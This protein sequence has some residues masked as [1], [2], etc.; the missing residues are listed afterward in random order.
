MP[1]YSSRLFRSPIDSSSIATAGQSAKTP[2]HRRA[3]PLAARGST[4]FEK[5][6]EWSL[7]TECIRG[8]SVRLSLERSGTM[9]TTRRRG[10]SWNTTSRDGVFKSETTD[11]RERE[12][13]RDL[14]RWSF[15]HTREIGLFEW[16][17]EV[18]LLFSGEPRCFRQSQRRKVLFLDFVS[19][20]S[21]FRDQITHFSGSFFS[22]GPNHKAFRGGLS[23]V[24]KKQ[25][26]VL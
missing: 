15:P 14:A 16:R 11:T 6:T 7:E 20:F 2:A 22:S 4:F 23:L 5:G 18:W 9:R 25:Q 19:F 3:T 8:S 1:R 12:R 17:G 21:F 24:F 10:G 26:S 13:E